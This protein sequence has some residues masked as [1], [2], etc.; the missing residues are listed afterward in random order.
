[1]ERISLKVA[2]TQKDISQTGV[3]PTTL[4]F[5]P[6]RMTG[7][8][9]NARDREVLRIKSVRIYY[10]FYPA[11]SGYAIVIYDSM[12]R[13]KAAKDYMNYRPDNIIL[14]LNQFISDSSAYYSSFE[15][16]LIAPPE[17]HFPAGFEPV[18]LD[19]PYFSHVLEV[20]LNAGLYKLHADIETHYWIE[21]VPERE[22]EKLRL[23]FGDLG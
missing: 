11:A 16:A 13:S 17:W 18:F 14:T 22:Y 15:T 4:D 10:S 23:E 8:D 2:R 12:G 19:C 20:K 9:V 1:M 7:F 3:G 5:T 21:K 6:T